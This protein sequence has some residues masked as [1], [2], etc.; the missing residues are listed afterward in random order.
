MACAAQP[1]TVNQLLHALAVRL[2]ADHDDFQP[3]RVSEF[4]RVQDLCGSLIEV[5]G[6]G[7]AGDDGGRIVKFVHKSVLDYLTNNPADLGI[8][9]R[10]LH[11]FFVDVRGG[12]VELGRHCLKYLS[13]RRYQ[14][15]VADMGTI[16]GSDG[17]EH[18]FL[19]YSAAFWF[20]HLGEG[21]PSPELFSEVRSFLRSPA[22]W[23]CLA[24]QAMAHPNL[25]S[26]YTSVGSGFE[27]GRR[28]GPAGEKN[29]A[30]P[31]P[32]WL[33]GC[34]PDGHR[35]TKALQ[36]YIAEWHGMLKHSDEPWGHCMMDQEGRELFAGLK[37]MRCKD[38]R[39]WKIVPPEEESPVALTDVVFD[40][41]SGLRARI[42][43]PSGDTVGWSEIC[44]NTPDTPKHHVIRNLDSELDFG[45]RVIRFSYSSRHDTTE[46]QSAW[47]INLHNMSIK[48]DGQEVFA[49]L[50]TNGKDQ[51]ARWGMVTES[52]STIDNRTAYGIH[53]TCSNTG[54]SLK[55]ETDSGYGGSLSSGGSDHSNDSDDEWNWDSDSGNDSDDSDEQQPDH[56][57]AESRPEYNGNIPTSH[58]TDC[59]V[60]LCE[61]RNPIVDSWVGG[62]DRSQTSCA[63]HPSRNIAVWSRSPSELRVLD[64]TTAKVSTRKIVEPAGFNEA[65]SVVVRGMVGFLRELV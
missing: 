55:R 28:D 50:S 58:S 3:G 57:D 63:F 51:G 33:P 8:E 52:V 23:T 30:D 12:N 15:R 32:R 42:A 43:Y 13:Y 56:S 65:A 34:E 6:T 47:S 37:S 64:M 9:D 45:D 27:V 19:K 4:K 10:E 7:E 35:Y 17:G 20:L 2:D 14:G 44:T 53:F 62:P 24:V 16:L 18:A 61:G 21:E 48:Y 1:L 36:E 40:E 31:L 11:R 46:G 54:E 49:G 25:F 39:H 26:T 5:E 60:F 38:V 29:I 22:F 41:R 59:L